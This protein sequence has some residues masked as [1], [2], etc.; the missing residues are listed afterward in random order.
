MIT[1]IILADD[2]QAI[3]DGV[4]KTINKEIDL[5][6]VNVVHNG[7][8]LVKQAELLNPDVIVSDIGM[9]GLSGL[10]LIKKLNEVSPKTKIIFLSMHNDVE[11]IKAYLNSGLWAY[12]LKDS[13]LNQLVVSIRSVKKGVPFN[14]KGTEQLLAYDSQHNNL[15]PKLTKREIQ[16]IELIAQDQK[17]KEIAHFLNVE[18]STIETHKKNIFRK[19]GV[20]TAVGLVRYA[21]QHKLLT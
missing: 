12:V 20:N 17:V 8:D 11:L 7:N 19:L 6:V 2:H 18:P 14:C 10:N 13:S 21:F 5:S 3:T 1:T 9:P 4:E 16:I 15:E